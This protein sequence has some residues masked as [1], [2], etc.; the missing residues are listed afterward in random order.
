[1]GI[2]DILN[3]TL[4]SMGKTKLTATN[5]VIGMIINIVLSIT[6][7]KRIGIL[8]IAIASSVAMV[9][10]ALLLIMNIIK[11]QGKLKVKVLFEKLIKVIVST[12][13]MVAIII[14]I[15]KF[16]IGLPIIIHI[17][18]GTIIG[19]LVY[20]CLTYMLKIEEVREILTVLKNKV[21]S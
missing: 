2:R 10:T 14:L 17:L 16:T 1:M 12:L 21:S 8:G 19:A 9:V 18:I 4:F 3:S 7:S 13:G 15:S 5:G 11:L 6:L 20:F